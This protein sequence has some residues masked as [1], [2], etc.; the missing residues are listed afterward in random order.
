ML[1]V[2]EVCK[3]ASSG[4]EPCMDQSISGQP[5]QTRQPLSQ[6]KQISQR[7]HLR[8]ARGLARSLRLRLTLRSWVRLLRLRLGRGL[9]VVLVWWLWAILV[10]THVDTWRETWWVEEPAGHACLQANLAY[11]LHLG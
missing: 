4:Q 1:N 10:S 2:P 6:K 11:N 7:A 9:V 3:R 8:C 5:P